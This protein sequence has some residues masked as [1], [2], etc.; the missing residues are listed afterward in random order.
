VS[1]AEVGAGPPLTY[2]RPPP[3]APAEAD[4]AAHAEL[5]AYDARATAPGAPTPPLPALPLPDESCAA[6]WDR[7][8]AE[9]AR[10]G[11]VQALRRRLVQM[12]FPIRAGISDD[13]AYR[14]A[15]RKGHPP[16][17]GAAG[18][19]FDEP[20]A[21]RVFVHPTTAGRVPVVA[22]GARQDFVRLVQALTG[23]NE[24]IPVPDSMGACIVGN[25]NNWDRVASIR[26]AWAEAPGDHSDAA[27]AAALAAL[28]PQRERYQ[29]RFILLSEGPYSATP[30]DA[31]GLTP[32]AWHATSA[33]IR[34]EHECAHYFTRRVF[35]SMRNNLLDELLA[36]YAGLVAGTG[37]FEPAW[38][39]RFMG[40]EC[41]RTYRAGGRL[42]NYRGSPALSDAAFALLQ[43]RVREAAAQIAHFDRTVR[44]P[45]AL[46]VPRVLAALFVL[47]LER[48][49]AAD[50]SAALA[51]A[52]RHGT[53]PPGP[54]VPGPP[55]P[56]AHG[57]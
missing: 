1:A 55:V 48:L 24:P 51:F 53:A 17:A 47:G 54:P 32:R 2:Y 4:R 37:R 7:Y 43:R 44:L 25:Y 39:L 30:A 38:F 50:G 27:W 31:L 52:V 12:Q 8:A 16:P 35:G 33:T 56:D 20:A 19:L 49:S 3:D 14:A 21:V 45:E 23:R 9:A 34:L 46:E 42:E 26:A 13:P 11:A 6:V 18:L 15:T 36:D 22:A 40:L 28:A 41:D 10:L 29:D 57:S 5:A